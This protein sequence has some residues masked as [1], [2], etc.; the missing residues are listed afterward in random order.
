MY[1]IL[2]ELPYGCKSY[3]C[4][5]LILFIPCAHAIYQ[6]VRQHLTYFK[7]HKVLDVDTPTLIV[8]VYNQTNV[9]MPYSINQ[10]GPPLSF[11]LTSPT[12]QHW[13]LLFIIDPLQFMI[14]RSLSIV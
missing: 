13:D 12:T 1:T 10:H 6:R 9:Y 2:G 4:V 7:N 14:Y 11:P 3:F 5:F 8:R